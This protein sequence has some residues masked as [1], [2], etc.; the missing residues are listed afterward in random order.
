MRRNQKLIFIAAGSKLLDGGKGNSVGQSCRK[1][2][3]NSIKVNAEI[4]G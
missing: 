1:V 4:A 3:D 2:N